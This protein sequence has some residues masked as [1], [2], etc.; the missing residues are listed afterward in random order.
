MSS[1]STHVLD[2]VR[3]LP[4]QGVALRL[5]AAGQTLAEGT[6]DSDGRHR[7]SVAL[8]AGD[9]ELTF[10][11]GAYFAAAGEACFY[12]QVSITFTVDPDRPHFHVPI[13]LSPFAYSTYRGS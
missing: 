3:G 13:L 10:A 5:S 7:F 11:T 8:D 4:A 2:A 1:L 9:Y 12:P 6:T